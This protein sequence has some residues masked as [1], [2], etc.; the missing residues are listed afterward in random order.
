MFTPYGQDEIGWI[1][2]DKVVQIK[3][4]YGIEFDFDEKLLKFAAKKLE[5][6]T[7][8]DLRMVNEFLKELISTTMTEEEANC[9]GQEES[10]L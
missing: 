10:K 9:K 2:R 1:I 6:L 3:Q 7:K 8:G 4:K 5:N